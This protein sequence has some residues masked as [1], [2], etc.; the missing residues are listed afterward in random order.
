MQ[1][2]LVHTEDDLGPLKHVK[3]PL[4]NRHPPPPPKKKKKKEKRKKEKEH[5]GRQIPMNKYS[6]DTA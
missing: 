2:M 1:F 3:Y 6:K 5:Y 4:K